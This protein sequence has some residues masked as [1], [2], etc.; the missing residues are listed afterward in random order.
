MISCINCGQCVTG[1]FCANCGQRTNV[2]R[3]TFREGWNDFWARIYG[4]DGMFPNT[5][6]DLT[7]RPGKAVRIFISGNRAKYYG[8]VGY[9]FLMVTLLI[10][11]LDLSGI[12][13]SMFLKN[14]SNSSFRPEIKPGSGQEKFYQ[15]I[16]Q[17]MSDNY[18]LVAVVMIPFQAFCARFIFFRRSG[19]NYLEHT[20]LPFYV[21]GHFQWI[22]IL[23]VLSY[24]FTGY[25]A[26]SLLTSSVQTL[27]F[28]YAYSNFIDYQPKW[29]SFLKGL[30]IYYLTL[31]VFIF[32][33]MIMLAIL[34][35]VYPEIFD[36]VKPSN[37]K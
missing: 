10:L 31:V 9:F 24:K 22:S 12:E 23:S 11:I 32:I 29:K 2:K 25:F 20:V 27:F 28:C 13:L 4:F 3:I 34:I 26:S 33:V 35:T 15:V 16:I 1:N 30:G 17:F 18:K 8:P 6:R 36:L 5:L 7:I 37:N 19:L 21:Q 14:V